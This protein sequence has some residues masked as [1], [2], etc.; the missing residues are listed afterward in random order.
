MAKHSRRRSHRVKRG[1]SGNYSSASSYGSYVN[2]SG[3]SQ[4][5]RVFD[6]SGPYSGRESNIIVGAQGQNAQQPGFPSAEQTSRIQSAGKRHR[7]RGGFLGEVINQAVVPF[8][9]LGLQQTYRRKK[10]GGRKTRKNR[11]HSRRH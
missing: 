8:T 4:F 5:S 7:K 1:G 9:L 10:N 3:N 2:G 6:Q 11:K